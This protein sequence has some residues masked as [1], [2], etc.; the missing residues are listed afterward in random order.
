MES[1]KNILLGLTEA[2]AVLKPQGSVNYMLSVTYFL[3]E[4]WHS[5]GLRQASSFKIG[6]VFRIFA[7]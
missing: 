2:C 5:N 6:N 4:Q 3:A 7:K 1:S